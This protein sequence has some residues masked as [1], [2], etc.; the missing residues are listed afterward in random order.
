M[1]THASVILKWE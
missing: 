1:D